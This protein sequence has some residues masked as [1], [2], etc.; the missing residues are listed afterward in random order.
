[1]SERVR[2]KD[3]SQT[4]LGPISDWPSSLKTLV[5]L[6][7]ENKFATIIYWGKELTMELRP[8]ALYEDSLVAAITWLASEMKKRHNLN[9]HVEAVKEVESLTDDTKA[10]V[11]ECVR[12]L[13]FNVVKYAGVG[14]AKVLLGKEDGYIQV[15]V[16]DRG[17]GFKNDEDAQERQPNGFGLFSIR[18]RLL[19]LGGNMIIQSRKG[20]G[21]TVILTVPIFSGKAS[22]ELSVA[23]ETGSEAG[24]IESSQSPL[25]PES[26]TR[27][28]V[29]DDHTLVR[30]G[31]TN[32]INN[33]DRL[34]VIGEAVDGV[35]AIE[36]VERQRPDV[37]LMDINM[38]RMNG[39]EATREIHRCW[40]EIRIIGLSVQDDDA[41]ARSMLQAGAS[42][43]LPKAGDADHLISA[44]LS[45]TT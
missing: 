42:S 39:I 20:E 45:L 13:L 17:R 2:A 8:P 33:D 23:T 27:V 15:T 31:I 7:L 4:P 14:E 12:E 36:T 35:A 19:A 16:A 24:F 3:W 43:F 26:R 29:V 34:V 11:F 44:I 37:V 6:I 18:E 38:P 9:T 5:N 28:V 10:L 41:S 21:T 32:I 22:Q 40:P 25:A 1:M 30:Q